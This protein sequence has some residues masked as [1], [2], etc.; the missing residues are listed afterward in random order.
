VQVANDVPT[1]N[2]STFAPSF[3]FTWSDGNDMTS[4]SSLMVGEPELIINKISPVSNTDSA[5]TVTYQV[6][7]MHT[8]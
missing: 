8:T 1:N 5:R 4:V 3:D 6:E 2:G 7:L